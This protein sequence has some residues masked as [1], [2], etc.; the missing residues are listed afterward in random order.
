MERNQT[1]L[2]TC[3]WKLRLRLNSSLSEKKYRGHRMSLDGHCHAITIAVTSV[4]NGSNGGYRMSQAKWSGAH[5]ARINSI[6]IR[7]TMRSQ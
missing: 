5:Y 2:H 7:P 6:C 3:R 1:A 4:S